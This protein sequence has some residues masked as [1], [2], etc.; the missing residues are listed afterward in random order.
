MGQVGTSRLLGTS[1][2]LEMIIGS[3]KEEDDT[4]KEKFSEAVSDLAN[5]FVWR[6]G[7]ITITKASWSV[8]DS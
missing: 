6:K 1:T 7:D 5:R 4:K 8:D 3:G 2:H